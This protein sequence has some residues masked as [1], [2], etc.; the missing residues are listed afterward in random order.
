LEVSDFLKGEFDGIF[1]KFRKETFLIGHRNS[2]YQINYVL[3]K[4][5]V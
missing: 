4:I 2:I 1:A 5:V 3:L